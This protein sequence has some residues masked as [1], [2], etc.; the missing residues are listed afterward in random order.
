MNFKSDAVQFVRD[1]HCAN[2]APVELIEK[3]M[4]FGAMRVANHAV[5]L[6]KKS[7]AE[8]EEKRIKGRMHE[9]QPRP[10]ELP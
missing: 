10:I 7:K 5:N 8:L 2:S 1:N 9:H 3:A 6:L 4:E